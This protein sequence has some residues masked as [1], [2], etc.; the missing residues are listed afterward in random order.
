MA[1]LRMGYAIGHPDTLKA[2]A[3]HKT[4]STNVVT[5]AAAAASIQDKAHIAKQRDQIRGSLEATTRVFADMGFKATD[6]QANFIL[7]DVKQPA[8]DFR[9]ACEKMGVA[10]GR[11]FPP[12]TTHARITIGTQEEMRTAN[13]VFKKVLSAS[14]TT[15][16]GA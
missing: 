9:D 1:G 16:A 12:L 3:P 10:I 2:I 11:D 13:D 8:K 14:K 4:G 7:V 6:S 5:L 15:T